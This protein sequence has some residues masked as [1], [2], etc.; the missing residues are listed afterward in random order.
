M[1]V[2]K[3]LEICSGSDIADFVSMALEVVD[4]LSRCA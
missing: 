2:Q 4:E 3:W 1:Q